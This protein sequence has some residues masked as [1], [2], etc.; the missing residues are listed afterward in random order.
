LLAGLLV[1]GLLFREATTNI[2]LSV[3][4]ELVGDALTILS[5]RL[6]D[7]VVRHHESGIA[8]LHDAMS[9]YDAGDGRP[10]EGDCRPVELGELQD[11]LAVDTSLEVCLELGI[12]ILG[13]LLEVLDLLQ[14]QLQIV[15][16]RLDIEG[17]LDRE[18]AG[19][20]TRGD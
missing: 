12:E 3:L 11:A 2:R 7:S 17:C 10:T 6:L 14:V 9:T 4:T 5:E 20:H 18:D 15:E 1:D 8:L 19:S 16:N 13:V